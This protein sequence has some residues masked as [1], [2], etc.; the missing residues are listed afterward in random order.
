M[1][2][3]LTKEQKDKF[4]YYV[5]KWTKIGLSTEPVNKELAED[6]INQCYE[7]AKLE[8]PKIIWVKSPIAIYLVIGILSRTDQQSGDSVMD[9]VMDSVRASVSASVRTS[10]MDSVWDS[11]RAS[12]MDSVRASVSASVRTSVMDSVWDSVWASVRA[13]I[14]GS[15]RSSVRDSVWDSVWNSI[16]ASVWNSI[17]ASVRDSVR[18]SVSASVRT[19]VMDSVWD[20]VRASVR[21]S[22]RDSVWDSVRASVRASVRDSVWDSVRASVYGSHES[23]WLS[24]YDYFRDHFPNIA[25]FKKLD[26]LMNLSKSCGWIYP[27]KNICIASERHSILNRDEEGRLHSLT[28]PAVGYP[29]GWNIYAVHGVRVPEYIIMNPE[30]I[31]IDKIKEENNAEIRRI[32]VDKIGFQRYIEESGLKSIHKDEYGELYK[33][34]LEDDEPLVVVKVINSTA[35]PDGTFK[36][37]FLR[38]PP[39]EDKDPFKIIKGDT[40]RARQAIAWT[41]KKQ[42]FEYCPSIET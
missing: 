25:P 38:V 3:R 18:A 4:P 13:S 26:G 5:D 21:A 1:I 35:E 9:S 14:W 22:V 31:T 41:F 33:S 15:V 32:M 42:E 11:V 17:G 24:F 36:E 7:I 27:G 39:N 29:D 37:Y 10:V 20:S 12:V 23:S 2:K 8:R 28:E 30:S 40:I 34:E 16:G 6:A 19:S